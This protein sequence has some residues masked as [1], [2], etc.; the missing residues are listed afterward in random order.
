MVI[1]PSASWFIFGLA[2][3]WVVSQT[4]ASSD[5]LSIVIPA[6]SLATLFFSLC[7]TL[8]LG[9]SRSL[10]ALGSM[11]LTA[12]Y[13]LLALP[14]VRMGWH[15]PVIALWLVISN[16]KT[17]LHPLTVAGQIPLML[18]PVYLLWKSN[19][20]LAIA[21]LSLAILIYFIPAL[22]ICFKRRGLNATD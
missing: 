16:G 21:P 9:R 15:S 6:T 3:L 4:G 8:S 5:F 20:S 11:G 22:V 13:F 18:S 19:Q 17:A 10:L 12:L 7:M 1:S 14:F 2:D